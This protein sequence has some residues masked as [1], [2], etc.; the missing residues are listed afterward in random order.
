MRYAYIKAIECYLPPFKLTNQEIERRFPEWPA[1][2]IEEKLGIVERSISGATEY[3]SDLAFMAAE[4]LFS[5]SLWAKDTIDLLVLC[6]QTPDFL[7]PTTACIVQNRLSLGRTTAAFDINMGCSGF[8]YGLSV[9]KAYIESDQAKTVLLITAD[10]YSKFISPQDKNLVTLFGDGASA[11]LIVAED[12][13]STP[14]LGPFHF[15]TDG[16]GAA[17]LVISGA[18]CKITEQ[19]NAR[20]YMNGPEVFSFSIREVPEAIYAVL[21]KTGISLDEID[22]FVLHQANA[23]ILE[24]IRKKLRIPREKFVLAMRETGNTVSSSIPIAL[25]SEIDAGTIAKGMKVL[26]VGFGGGYST[27]AVI[28]RL[29]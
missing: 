21:A 14:S 18:G 10:T 7:A 1:S 15:H 19:H 22:R 3:T 25:K 5:S 20:L 2:K 29:R 8:V 6:T 23:Y 9:A 13:P 11:T 24:H 16:R 28:V 27:A 12:N 26:L 17:H 4:K